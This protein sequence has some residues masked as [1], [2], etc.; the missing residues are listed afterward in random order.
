MS[1]F[2]KKRLAIFFAVGA[3]VGIIYMFIGRGDVLL[4]KVIDGLLAASMV[5]LL[6]GGFGFAKW[7]GSFDFLF[8]IEKRSKKKKEEK[9]PSD[10]EDTPAEKPDTSFKEPLLAGGVY[11][12]IGM[13]MALM[14][15]K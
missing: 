5:P 1:L 10:S 7:A 12:I 14:F 13:G 9:N 8:F 6:M 4:Y 11:F 2:S 15:Y 3:A